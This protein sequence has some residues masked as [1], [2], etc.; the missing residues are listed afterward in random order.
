MKP[1][2]SYEILTLCGCVISMYVWCLAVIS[3][4]AVNGND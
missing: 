4:D 1:P 3:K 2:E